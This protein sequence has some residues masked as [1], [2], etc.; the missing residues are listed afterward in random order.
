MPREI[1]SLRAGPLPE[2]ELHAAL[3]G[4]QIHALYQPIVRLA[5]RRPIGLEAL[6]RL[7]HPQLG[8]L[9]P[10][11]FVAPM[12]RAGLARQLTEE[13]ARRAFADWAGDRLDAMDL[14]LSI[15][16]P[17]DV[18]LLP[19]AMRWLDEARQDAAI[20][21]GRLIVELTESQPLSRLGELAAA[22]ETL[23]RIGYGV[24]IDDVGPDI[25]DHA[26]LLGLPFTMLKLDKLVV[27]QAAGSEIARD[28]VARAIAAAR[29][30]HMS[31]TAE[32]VEDAACWSRLHDL[33]AD[34][35]QGFLIA[36]PLALAS[37]PSWHDGWSGK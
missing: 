34:L 37:V 5:D 21:A 30:A 25:R 15:N 20:P 19:E 7:H 24:A 32:G 27:R 2:S 33:G 17:L 16:V 13:M 22:L 1:R 23:R 35:A 18:L 10:G 9:A 12:E 14:T 4:A 29:A 31:V 8:T 28:F 36:R 11:L 6:A 3:A 26:P